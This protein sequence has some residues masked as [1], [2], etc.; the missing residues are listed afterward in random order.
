M[1]NNRKMASLLLV[2]AVLFALAAPALAQDDLDQAHWCE[3]VTIRFFAGGTEGDAFA[4]IV[5]RGA[6]AAERD[7]GANVEYV[8]SGWDSELMTQQ[9]REAVAQAP[10]GIAMM[11]H[12]GNEAIMPL[13]AEA[14]E[15]GI[16]M[17][18]QNVDVDQV[19]AR[20]GGGYVGAQLYSQGRALGAE[21]V[22]QF[23]IGAGDKAIVLANL[24]QRERAL[25][26]LGT[27]EVLEEA[28]V[29]IVHVDSAPTWA[30]DPNIGIPAMVAALTDNPD[31]KLVVFS[32]GQTLGNT[33]TYFEAAGLEAGQIKAV[34]FD[35]NEFIM[36]GFAEDWIHLTADQQPFLQ[37]YLPV[38]SICL[39]AKF[40]LAPLN[41]D[42]GAGFIDTSNY[43]QVSDLA[44][45]GYR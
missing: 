5:Y 43:E 30:A 44:I 25:R 18:Y 3:G 37:G 16:I 29:E 24:A 14:A 41:A 4:G 1:S 31:V 33:Q 15:A 45:A 9:L 23:G 11:G 27:W 42:T 12:P 21:A 8:F 10:D 38:L 17:M 19:R 2:A 34:G 35:T 39:T 13:A 22:R 28:G 36:Q 20:Y 6:L 40:G 32:G 26:E 7:L